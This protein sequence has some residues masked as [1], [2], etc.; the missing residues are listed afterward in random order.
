MDSGILKK[1]P[2]T[3]LARY[4]PTGPIRK[5]VNYGKCGSGVPCLW[6]IIQTIRMLVYWWLISTFAFEQY[7]VLKQLIT[8]MKEGL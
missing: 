7:R 1:D 2:F 8:E 5:Q 6:A 4:V 3:W